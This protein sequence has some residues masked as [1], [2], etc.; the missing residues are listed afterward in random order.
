M[1]IFAQQYPENEKIVI[2]INTSL[3]A[4]A[5]ISC[6]VVLLPVARQLNILPESEMIA[7]GFASYAEF[8]K[9]NP[10]STDK[11]KQCNG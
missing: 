3:I 8:M 7:M 6:S 9:E 5:M 2:Y 10:P 4:G 1:T 11:V